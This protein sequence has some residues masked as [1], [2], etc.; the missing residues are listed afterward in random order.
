MLHQSVFQYS[1]HIERE[2][3]VCDIDNDHYEYLVKNHLEDERELLYNHLITKLDDPNGMILAYN[4]SFEK[5]ILRELNELFPYHDKLI[6]PLIE[7]AFDLMHLLKEM[8]NYL[9]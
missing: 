3:G 8:P 1:L 4:V 2:P 6:N 9:T 7:D 5:R